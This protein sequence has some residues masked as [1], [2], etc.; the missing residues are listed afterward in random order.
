MFFTPPISPI[1]PILDPY[2]YKGLRVP[3]DMLLRGMGMARFIS[4]M[5]VPRKQA[6]RMINPEKALSVQ[7]ARI[8]DQLL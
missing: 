2:S 8:T 1:L 3:L 7:K 6:F 5:I 4:P